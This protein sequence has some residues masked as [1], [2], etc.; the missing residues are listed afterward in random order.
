MSTQVAESREI[1]YL[2]VQGD[3][4]TYCIVLGLC[5]SAGHGAVKLKD[6]KTLHHHKSSCASVP[7][8]LHAESA[9]QK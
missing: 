4:E 6:Q 7:R 1:A 9:V 5:T 8:V 3:S 2:L